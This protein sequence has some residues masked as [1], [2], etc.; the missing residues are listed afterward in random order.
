MVN[1]GRTKKSLYKLNVIV[2]LLLAVVLL[3]GVFSFDANIAAAKKKSK[4]T[5]WQRMLE[6]NGVDRALW[7][8][9]LPKIS[10]GE[11]RK[12]TKLLKS[13]GG[14]AQTNSSS[15]GPDI[16][17][18]LIE[19]TKSDLKDS[20]F[21]IHANKNY[22]IRNKS[23]SVVASVAAGSETKVRYDS[24][25]KLIAYG[26]IA[27]ASISGEVVFDAADGNNSNLIFDI[28]KPDSSY[29]QYR[30]KMKLR[31]YDGDG[32]DADRIWAINILPME[33][34]V[35]GMGETSGTGPADFTRVMTIIFR[36]YGYWK[37]EY[38]TKYAG[39]GFKVTATSSSQVYRGY[40]WETA[41]PKIKEAAGVTQGKVVMYKNEL[42]LTPYCSYTDGHTRDYPDDDYPYLKSVK[43][44]KKGTKKGLKPGDGGN[45]MWGLSANGALG[46]VGDGK[47]WDWVLKHY[48]SG[49]SITGAY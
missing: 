9:Y 14:A 26:S 45:H 40:D 8:K 27:E 15:L 34:Y 31:Y 2:I 28:N 32:S 17:V 4:A 30:G 16:S 13:T 36:T 38:G 25:N 43:D 1:A 24:G 11:Y 18:G 7:E 6:K 42:A 23:G 49:V 41:H 22:N 39:Q 35:W 37:I 21:R 12:V 46:F 20:P 10:R 3:S 47:S 5:K 29:D 19:Y 44:H 48:Y 33:Q